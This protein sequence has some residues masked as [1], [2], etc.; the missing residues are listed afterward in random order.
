MTLSPMREI[1]ARTPVMPGLT[2]KDAA[3][4]GDLAHALTDGGIDVFDVLMRT[5][6]AADAIAAMRRA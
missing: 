4:A 2:I 5:P 3:I 1:L 6:A